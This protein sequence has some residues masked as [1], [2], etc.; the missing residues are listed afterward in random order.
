VTTTISED[1]VYGRPVG[2]RKR[3]RRPFGL[4]VF[5]H[6]TIPRYPLTQGRGIDHWYRTEK[7]RDAALE[8]FSTWAFGNFMSY[9]ATK[10][11]DDA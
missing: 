5:V 8:A 4:R 9:S 3:K 11:E 6:C 2:Q 7:A 10:I 1:E